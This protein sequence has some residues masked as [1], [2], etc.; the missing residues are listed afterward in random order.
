MSSQI[1]CTAHM[2]TI[3][4]FILTLVLERVHYCVIHIDSGIGKR[5]LLRDSHWSPYRQVYAIA[6]FIL[7]VVLTCNHYC[8][9]HIDPGVGKCTYV[10]NCVIHIDPVSGKSTLFKFTLVLSSYQVLKRLLICCGDLGGE[11]PGTNLHPMVSVC[12]YQIQFYSQCTS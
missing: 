10:H 7:I 5:T 3:E 6:W 1:S 9:I 2:Y 11:M 12:I 8:V 4:S